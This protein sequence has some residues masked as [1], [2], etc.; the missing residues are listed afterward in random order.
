MLPAQMIYDRLAVWVIQTDRVY[1]QKT[2]KLYETRGEML[3]S[4]GAWCGLLLWQIW[5]QSLRSKQH[6][7]G[8]RLFEDP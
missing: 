1:V 6:R 8:L 4:L 7:L 3:T 2:G 5:E